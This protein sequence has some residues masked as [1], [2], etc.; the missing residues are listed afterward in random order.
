M[1]RDKISFAKIS[2]N[3]YNLSGKVSAVEFTEFGKP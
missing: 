3:T 1:A 2:E